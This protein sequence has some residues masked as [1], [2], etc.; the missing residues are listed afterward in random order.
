MWT[1]L[2]DGTIDHTRAQVIV[3]GL[4]QLDDPDRGLLEAK[5]LT[6]AARPHR[7]QTR[8]YVVAR[9]LV[10]HRPDLAD[11]HDDKERAKA[12]DRRHLAVFA[13]AHG[14]V[15]LTGYHRPAPPRSCSPPS[16]R[17]PGTH[18]DDALTTR[19]ASTPWPQ[20]LAANTCI[21]VHVDVVIPGHPG[22]AAQHRGQHH[23]VRPGRR[24]P[25]L[26]PGTA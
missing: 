14:M 13:R 24:R 15:D 26:R 23:R 7:H 25:R 11:D 6:Y 17:S 1:A 19:N 3:D 5:A 9:L 4:I 20:I 12:W 10:D 2:A 18:D 16:I 8:R 21:D 22:P